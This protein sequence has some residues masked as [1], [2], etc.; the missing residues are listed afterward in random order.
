MSNEVSG[1]LVLFARSLIKEL[2]CTY[3]IEEPTVSV[4]E[5]DSIDIIYASDGM[6]CVLRSPEHGLS[7]MVDTYRVLIRYT[8]YSEEQ[9]KILAK[10]I[11]SHLN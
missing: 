6:H 3:G 7:V 11:I 5:P 10:A 1:E 2:V 9:A 4:S 8:S